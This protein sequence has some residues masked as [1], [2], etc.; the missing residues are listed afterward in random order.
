MLGGFALAC[1][2]F[3]GNR[4]VKGQRF[5]CDFR[6]FFDAVLI[7]CYV[8]VNA[9]FVVSMAVQV[10]ECVFFYNSL[11]GFI[12]SFDCGNFFFIAVDGANFVNQVFYIGVDSNIAH[13]PKDAGACVSDF[14]VCNCWFCKACA[15]YH[16][17]E[18]RK[19]ALG[20]D[21]AYFIIVGYTGS[22][23]IFKL[24]RCRLADFHEVIG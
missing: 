3:R 2:E 20:I 4:R 12:P 8:C 16:R 21:G 14:N 9:E 17:A 22:N 11:V 7:A 6:A 23:R 24:G 19:R 18:I 1:G 15:F 5:F 13:V 10:F